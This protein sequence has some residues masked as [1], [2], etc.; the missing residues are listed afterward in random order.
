MR[1]VPS[2]R[3]ATALRAATFIIAFSQS[4]P[5]MLL[6]QNI[7]S[8]ARWTAVDSAFGRSGAAQAG[9]VMKYSFPRSDLNI[10]VDGVTVKPAFALGSWVAFKDAG[11]GESM[12]MGDLVLLPE[13]VNGVIKALQQGGVEQTALHNHLLA[14]VMYLHIAAHGRAAQIGATIRTALATTKTPLGTPSGP[15]APSAADLD[16]A[17][18]ALALGYTGKLNGIVYQVSIPRAERITDRMHEVPPSMGVATAINFQPTGAG[19]AAIT[20]DFVLKAGEVNPVIRALESH[21]IQVEAVHSHMLFEAPRL[22]FLHFWANDDAFM[23]AKGL[24]AA[25]DH[26]ASKKPG[27]R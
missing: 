5:A 2:I 12:A 22:F 6:A 27:R 17:G 26:T 16:T 7:A 14:P 21:G 8:P 20:G 10:T 15:A 11:H 18:I 25:L 13:E 24:H 3:P 4:F 9:D 1:L 19:R 23:L